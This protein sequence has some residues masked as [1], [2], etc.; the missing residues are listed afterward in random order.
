MSSPPRARS[1]FADAPRHQDSDLIICEESAFL[2]PEAPHQG[3]TWLNIST[4]PQSGDSVLEKLL[5]AKAETDMQLRF[6]LNCQTPEDEDA[7]K[8]M[9]EKRQGD[10]KDWI[11]NNLVDVS[12]DDEDPSDLDRRVIAMTVKE[13]EA[14]MLEQV[15]RNH[16]FII[17]QWWWPTMKEHEP[18][19][20]NKESMGPSIEH[21]D[22]VDVN[23]DGSKDFLRKIYDQR[24]PVTGTRAPSPS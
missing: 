3:G 4:P 7:L 13:E 9:K 15:K 16:E 17:T 12:S 21:Y 11:K 1:I 14:A 10:W 23:D 22:D 8:K 19:P 2:D 20:R 24:K 6:D 18:P 5:A